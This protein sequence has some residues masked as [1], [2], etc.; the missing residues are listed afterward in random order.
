MKSAIFGIFAAATLSLVSAAPQTAP[1]VSIPPVCV[2]C[3]VLGVACVAFC[4]AGG[5]ADPLC[6]ACAGQAE[7][8][9]IACLTVSGCASDYADGKSKGI[10]VMS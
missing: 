6:L 4:V 1:S 9:I 7:T 10:G 5:P 8:E 3:D 2:V